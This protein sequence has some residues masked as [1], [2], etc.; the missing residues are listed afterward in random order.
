[1]EKIHTLLSSLSPAAFSS[2]DEPWQGFQI[3]TGG[4]GL[5]ERDCQAIGAPA[6]YSVPCGS[7]KDLPSGCKSSTKLDRLALHR[8]HLMTSLRTDLQR[9]AR[10]KLRSTWQIHQLYPSH[11]QSMF[12]SAIYMLPSCYMQSMFEATCYIQSHRRQPRNMVCG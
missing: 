2:V 1:M 12:F 11:I 4:V 5:L 7:W 6:L 3:N 10:K 8:H 9:C